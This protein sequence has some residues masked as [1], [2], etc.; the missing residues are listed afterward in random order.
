M[1]QKRKQMTTAPRHL[2]AG[3]VALS[4]TACQSD[5]DVFPEYDYIAD[6]TCY[7]AAPSPYAY[8]ADDTEYNP[9]VITDRRSYVDIFCYEPKPYVDPKDS[10]HIPPGTVVDTL[11]LMDGAEAHDYDAKVTCYGIRPTTFAADDTTAYFCPAGKR[12]HTGEGA[13]LVAPST[14]T[15]PMFSKH[16]TDSTETISDHLTIGNV[17][18]YYVTATYMYSVLNNEE[19]RDYYRL[20][21][22]NAGDKIELVTYG[23]VDHFSKF[24]FDRFFG[25]LKP[26][27]LQMLSGATQC[28]N[29]VTLAEVDTAG[30]V[31]YLDK[32][33]YVDLSKMQDCHIFE[34]YIIFTDG[35]G[36]RINTVMRPLG[37][38]NAVLIDDMT[39][40]PAGWLVNHEK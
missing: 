16:M 11:G 34:P 1:R 17:R 2:Y 12:Y 32:W 31:K 23:Y 5:E 30:T 22:L 4:I 40:E 24:A 20:P 28:A 27:I 7:S 15:R 14:T 21:K 25:K 35:D 13:L 33:Q 3:I 37:A 26:G 10:L 36:D 6:F 9:M 19:L 39:F 29:K 38:L 18:G 8:L